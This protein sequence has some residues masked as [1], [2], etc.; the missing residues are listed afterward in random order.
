MAS[1]HDIIHIDFEANAG[2]VSPALKAIQASAADTRRA[3]ESVEQELRNLEQAGADSTAIEAKRKQLNALNRDVK[4]LQQA[5]REYV[6]GIGTLDKAIKAFNDGTLSQMSAAFQKA[7]YNAAKLAQTKLVPSDKDYKKTMDELNALMQRNL[8]NMAKARMQTDELLRAI[9][10]GGKVSASWLRQEKQNLEELLDVIPRGTAEWDEYSAQLTKIKNYVQTLS[11]AERR[12][13]GEIVNA[14]D[15]RQMANQLTEEGARAAARERE[16]AEATI[17]AQKEKIAGIEEERQARLQSAQA[18]SRQV[19]DEANEIELKKQAIAELEKQVAAENTASA[20]KKQSTEAQKAAEEAQAAA[21]AK[22]AEAETLYNQKVEERIQKEKELMEILSRSIE[23]D[24][25]IKRIN[26]EIAKL[27]ELIA[28]SEKYKK[29]FTQMSDEK[30][31]AGYMGKSGITDDERRTMYGATDYLKRAYYDRFSANFHKLG[32]IK[33]GDPGYEEDAAAS[34]RVAKGI[35]QNAQENLRRAIYRQ[36]QDGRWTSSAM[37]QEIESYRNM[38]NQ[39]ARESPLNLKEDPE[40]N[41]YKFIIAQMEKYLE[42]AKQVE[43][44]RAKI[45]GSS[46]FTELARDKDV[47]SDEP[48]EGLLRQK[49]RREH[50]EITGGTDAINRRKEE[51]RAKSEEVRQAKEAEAEAERRLSEA[52]KAGSEQTQSSTQ[53][54]KQSTEATSEAARQLATAKTELES[55]ESAHDG[56]VKALQ[57][58]QQALQRYDEQIKQEADTMQ[59]AEVKKAQN[60]ELTVKRMEE[61]VAMLEKENH[62]T[63]PA[64]TKQWQENK[65]TIDE[66][67][68]KIKEAKGEIISVQKAEDIAAMSGGTWAQKLKGA[69]EVTFRGTQEDLIKA[70]A[71][72]EKL[73][74]TATQGTD[75]W[76]K[77]KRE[78]AQ[79]N[80]EL[81]HGSITSERMQE[82]LAN[83]KAMYNV[84]EMKAALARARAEWELMVQEGEEGEAVAKKMAEAIKNLDLRTKELERDTKATASAFEK[85]WSRLKTYVGLYVGAA[86]AMQKITATMGDLMELSDKMGEVRKTTGFTADEVGRLST[87]LAKMDTRTTLTGLMELSAVAGQLGLK[88]EQDVRGFTEAANMLMVAL[89]EM[90]KEGATAMLKVALATGEIDKIRQQ[91]QD[92]LVE[93]SDAVSVAMTKIGSTIDSLR[94]NSAAAAP[95][96]TDFV[97]RVGAVGAQSGITIDQVAALGSTVDALGMRVEMSATALSRMIPA[98]KNNAFEIGKTIGIS[99]ERI[100]QMYNEGRAMEVIIMLLEKMR[101]MSAEDIEGALNTGGMAEVLKDLNQQGARAGIVFA[102]LSQ[103]VDELKRQLGVARTAYEENIAIMNEYN[104]MNETTAAKWQRLKNTFEEMFVGDQAQSTLGTIIDGLRWIV[105]LLAGKLSPALNAVGVALKAILVSVAATKLGFGAAFK[106]MWDWVTNLRTN[107]VKLTESLKAF[108]AAN[109]ANIWMAIAMAIYYV[110]Q[111]I[112]D[113]MTAVSEL[114]QEL[115]RM[116]NEMQAAEKHLNNLVNQFTAAAKKSE[117]AAK[118]HHELE[119]QTKALREEVE[120]LKAAN[121]GSAEATE[122]LKKK[123]EELKAAEKQL[124]QATDESNKANDDRLKLIAE[125]NTKYSTYLGYMLSE[126]TAA[127]QVASAHQ[128]IVAALKEELKQKGLARKQEALDAKY[129]EDIKEYSEDAIDELS[130]LPREVQQRIRDAWNTVQA[131]ITSTI[132]EQGQQTFG[133]SKIKGIANS[134]MTFT[135]EADLLNYLQG[136][137]QEIVSREVPIQEYRG[138]MYVKLG[139]SLVSLTEYLE[140]IWGGSMDDGFGDWAET[141]IKKEAELEQ[142]RHDSQVESSAAHAVTIQA[143]VDDISGNMKAITNTVKDKQEFTDDQIRQLAQNVNA[144][145]TDVQKYRNDLRDV[146]NV[147][148]KGNEETLENAVNTLLSTVDEKVRKQV[149]K[150]AKQ[151]TKKSVDEVNPSDKSVY[152]NGTTEPTNYKDMTADLLVARRKQMNEYVKAIQTDSD[153]PEMLSKDPALKKAIESG[154]ASDMRTV[155]EWYNTERLKI[156]DELYARHLTNTGDWKDPEKGSKSWRKELQNEFDT[157]LRILDAYY[158]ERKAEIE[159]AQSEEGLSEAEAQRLTIE[160]ETVWRKHRMELQKIY[161]GKSAEIADEERQRI[162]DILAKQDEDDATF[163]E[164][165][166]K[167]SIEKFNLL[168]SKGEQGEVE[169]NKI[170]SKLTKDIANDLYKQQNAVANQVEAIRKIIAQER[171]FDGLVENLEKNLSTMGVLFAELDKKRREAIAAGLEPEDDKMLRGEDAVNKRMLVLL[172]QAEDAYALTFDQLKEVMVNKGFAEWA[173]AIENDDQLRKATMAMLRKMYDDV[174][175][176]IKKESSQMKKELDIWWNDVAEGQTVS[177]KGGFEKLLS[178]LGLAEDQVK[179]ANSL[180]G[181]GAAS[182]RVADK[183][184]IQ[185]MRVRLAMQNAYYAKLKEIGELRIRQLNAEAEAADRQGDHERA[186]LLRLDAKHA[187]QALNLSL[188]EE[189]NKALEQQVAIQNQVVESQNRLYTE[190][191]A[192]ADLFSSSIQGVFEATNAGNEE[193]YN[194][195]AK[196]NL[197]GKGGPGAGTYVVIEDAGTSDATAHYEYL[198]EQAALERQHE[199]E[200]ENATREAWRK[201]MDDINMKL[202]ETITDTLNAMLQNQ[203]LDANTQAVLANTEA[204]KQQTEATAKGAEAIANAGNTQTAAPQAII[205]PGATEVNRKGTVSV[206][207]LEGG[208]IVMT[209]STPSTTPVTETITPSQAMD[210]EEALG[211]NPMLV[212]QEQSNLATKKMVEDMQHVKQTQ[213]ETG[214]SMSQSAQSTFAKMVTAAN[215]Y[216]VA[217]Q[218][219]SNDNMTTTQKFGMIAVQAAGQAAMTMLSVAMSQAIA[220]AATDSPGVLGKVWKTLGPVGG[221]A[222][223]AVFTG[224]LGGLMGL[225]ASKISKSKSEIASATGVSNSSTTAGRLVTG[226]KTYAEGNVNEFTDPASLTPGRQYNVDARDG[227]TYR[228]RYM[229]RNPKTHITNGPEFH[230]AG[231]RGREAIIDAKTTRLIRMNDTGIWQDI[232]TLYRGGS[233]SHAPRRG[234]GIRTFAAGNLDEFYSD[235][236]ATDTVAA[237]IDLASMQA[238]IDRNSAIQEALLERL[239]EPIYA[240]NIL[241]GSDGL[242]NVLAKLQQEAKRHGVKYM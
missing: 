139:Q 239:N 172:Q 73:V 62:D 85:A 169:F 15:A 227:R 190:L 173:D 47:L 54:T 48:Q 211:D 18:L 78:L 50:E 143:A 233:L 237:G 178:D 198:D 29:Q 180:I 104:K 91:M 118:K 126:K 114:D 217:Y 53:A 207:P 208:E 242:P 165:S 46:P 120:K 166:I 40:Y 79:V 220:Q 63:I 209:P 188:T 52:K 87:A 199:I 23:D 221:T 218:A 109:K 187:Q 191:K 117:E 153:I 57:E 110:G 69:A 3:V 20:N 93:G 185:Q 64:N 196:L 147:Y 146:E 175:A 194:E 100:E 195:L 202:S 37:E 89:P 160:N 9:E 81:Q 203:S 8:E 163:V 60:Q 35:V 162:Y 11:D 43:A 210:W 123:E 129:E 212:W 94:A 214:R 72:L 157:Y 75:E 219:M 30:F 105:D 181:A 39:A 116:D 158:T 168:K 98:I 58:E 223:F 156:Q 96:I 95:A 25:E 177:R 148:G 124:K 137:L 184:A 125:I 215:L 238:S 176:A 92:G 179:R 19:A 134:G 42:V 174:H 205:N 142:V 201:L 161:L 236:D 171:P 14:D 119:E 241:Y 152:G 167:R 24:P 107:V 135:N 141:V 74:K 101:G 88:T 86:V 144:V 36:I 71:R 84:K 130:A 151:A 231:E 55:L 80:L 193:Y 33:P 159:K 66:L 21:T 51:E 26:A 149:L 70:Q 108:Y 111:K 204:L 65:K 17:A 164:A 122:T 112:Y 228:A 5:E 229:G 6:K 234:R 232:Q 83:P 28:V 7:S 97:K 186:E 76:R 22:I 113:A 27:E 2:K 106:A 13:A 131:S 136:T 68:E 59:E 4:S 138:G 115:A 155:I 127:E 77:Y 38:M 213:V 45:A 150:V 103:N 182:E 90:G 183:L 41:A 67:T 154:M 44:E 32:L 34:E 56:N 140:G 1:R 206:G 224:L 216:G 128:L 197:T 133:L 61:I 31:E 10:S 82:I 230:L 121:D 16:E 226:M 192:W 49:D 240:Q 145:V 170:S 189:Q 99:Q 235:A 200:Q 132:N 225:A 102:G 222:A 12:L